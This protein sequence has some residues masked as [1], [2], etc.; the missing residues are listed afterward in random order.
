MV[1]VAVPAS[2]TEEPRPSPV[3]TQP[4]TRRRR[5]GAVVRP[6]LWLIAP[7]GLLLLVIVAVPVGLDAYLSFFN[8]NISTLAHAFSAPLSGIRN[9]ITALTSATPEAN[10]AV[11]ALGVS[12]GFSIVTTLCIAPIG[13]VVALALN[14]H[15]RGRG[16]WRSVFLVPYV[17]PTF[18]TAII[19]RMMFLNGTGLVDKVLAALHVASINTYWLL[20]PKTFWAMVLTDI[21]AS[22]PFIYIMVMAGLA[23]ISS[24]LYEAA[25]I[26]GAGYLAKIRFIVLPQLKSLLSLALLL[27][28]IYHFGNFTLPFILFGNPPPPAADGLPVDIYFRAFTSF[29]YGVAAATAVLMVIVLAIPGYIYLRASRLA[30]SDAA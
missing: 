26:D 14:H 1:D 5:S 13:F 24:E 22:W 16:I 28:T 3:S 11:V 7:A 29:Q 27:S 25:E 10:S 21:W 30:V 9:Y 8:V 20:G 19:A 12:L 17:I 15:F 2:P 23:S 18:V 6:P 4:A